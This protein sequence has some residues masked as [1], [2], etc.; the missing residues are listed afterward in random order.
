MSSQSIALFE[1]NQVE[2]SVGDPGFRELAHLRD[3]FDT[4]RELK[5]ATKDWISYYNIKKV[6]SKLSLWNSRWGI[7]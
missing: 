5:E 3:R 1:E 4:S 7:L 2:K 6:S